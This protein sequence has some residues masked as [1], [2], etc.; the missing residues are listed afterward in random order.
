MVGVKRVSGLQQVKKAERR[1]LEERLLR[2]LQVDLLQVQVAE[3]FGVIEIL[4]ARQRRLV[5][6]TQILS[7]ALRD[8]SSGEVFPSPLHLRGRAQHGRGRGSCR[9]YPMAGAFAIA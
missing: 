1:Y 7:R 9:T 2:R 8:L 4:E 3:R 5:L 6:K